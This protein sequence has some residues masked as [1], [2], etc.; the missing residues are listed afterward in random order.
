MAVTDL[1]GTIALLTKLFAIVTVRKIP[2]INII[3]QPDG[4]L[5]DSVNDNAWPDVVLPWG[6]DVVLPW[7]PDVVV[8]GGPDVVL[9]WGPDVVLPGEADVVLSG[10]PDVVLPWGPDVVLPGEADVV[11]PGSTA[12]VVVVVGPVPAW[13]LLF[14]MWCT[15][16]S[17][18][19][20][21]PPQ[22]QW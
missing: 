11:V 1:V 20:R 13:H 15:S 18:P 16:P 6:P 3:S 19:D 12:M 22:I 8:P 5:K 2:S 9:P 10:G 17:L 14:L 21:M 7:G 4:C